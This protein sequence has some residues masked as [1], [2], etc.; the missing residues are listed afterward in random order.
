MTTLNLTS[1]SNVSDVAVNNDHS[2]EREVSALAI[3]IILVMSAIIGIWGISCLVS[4]FAGT[5]GIA[6]FANSWVS[7]IT[8]L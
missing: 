1:K 6:E 5:S 3:G 2:I 4:G 8:G 7:A